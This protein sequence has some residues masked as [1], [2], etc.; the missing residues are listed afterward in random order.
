MLEIHSWEDIKN[1]GWTINEH[2]IKNELAD[3]W[4]MSNCR[5]AI[6][7]NS[8]FSWWGAWLGR[9]NDKKRV[10]IGPDNEKWPIKTEDTYSYE[11][12]YKGSEFLIKE[13]PNSKDYYEEII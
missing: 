11:T 5:H 10:V 3:L 4:L 13:F 12:I 9:K 6:L 1:H 8:S 7:A 2:N